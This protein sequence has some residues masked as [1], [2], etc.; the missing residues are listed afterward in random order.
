MSRVL[1]ISGSLR[2][3][4]FNTQLLE[5]LHALAPEG[6]HIEVFKQLGELPHFNEDLESNTPA[7]VRRLWQ[8]IAE[9]DGLIVATPEYNG[10]MP[11]VP[12]NAHPCPE[13]VA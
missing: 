4:S 2:A 5:G 6:M 7:A 10:A 13:P 9:A 1:A 12:K 11:G 8:A 3:D